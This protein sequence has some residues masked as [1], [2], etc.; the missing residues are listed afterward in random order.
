MEQKPIKIL[1]I[2]PFKDECKL[3]R[4]VNPILPDCKGDV[5]LLVGRIAS[6]KSVTLSNMLLR[7][8]LFGD[9]FGTIYLISNTA[10]NDDTSRFLVNAENV[11][12]YDHYSDSII[13]NINENKKQYEKKDME[14]DIIVGDDLLGSLR[15][16]P[17]CLLYQFVT[18]LRH[19]CF[20]MMLLTQ[21]MKAVPPV[22]RAN[23]SYMLV[24]WNNYS[25]NE[26]DDIENEFGSFCGE[27]GFK[28]YYKKYVQKSP[29]SFLYMNFVK[30]LVMK[31]F[32]Q[33]LY[34][35]QKNDRN[36]EVVEEVVEQ[37]E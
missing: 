31:N 29:Y 24:F 20:N 19:T 26:L 28:Y 22:V 3:R 27:M 14:W 10:G 8:E 7:P 18:R 15:S 35:V 4:K 30:G 11:V 21:K 25:D 13:R 23:T 37:E 2:K 17:P 5:G 12:T 32:E 6:G 1:P 36:Q 9:L 16:N 34:K 33:L